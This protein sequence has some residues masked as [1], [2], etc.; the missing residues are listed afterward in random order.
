MS[1]RSNRLVVHA[2]AAAKMVVK[3]LSVFMFG[4]T[5]KYHPGKHYMRGPGPQWCAKHG[6]V[7]GLSYGESR[8]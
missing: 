2:A 5:A 3:A 7:K 6:I 1:I 8:D 4:P